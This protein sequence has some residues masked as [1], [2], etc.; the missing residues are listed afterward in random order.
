MDLDLTHLSAACWFFV[1]ITALV[2]SFTGYVRKTVMEVVALAGVSLGAFSRAYYVFVRHTIQPDALWIS[3]AL[4]LYCLAM[5][6]K[7]L[8][9]VPNRPDYRPP[10]KSKFY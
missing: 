3:I 5:W 8:F 10:R 1:G 7:M 6:H 4:A 9:V 2:A